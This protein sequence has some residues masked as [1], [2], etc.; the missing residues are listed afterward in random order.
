MTSTLKS[1]FLPPK[2]PTV[3]ALFVAALLW[4]DAAPAQIYRP[5]RARRT[6]N[7]DQYTLVIQKNSQIDLL[8]VSGE[9]LLDNAFP[10]V[11]FE[12]GKELPL[13]IDFKKTNRFSV[14]SPIGKGN[15]FLYA[16]EE[17]EWRIATYPG[18]GCMT[19]D[20][21]F[22]NNTK[23]PLTV[24]GLSPL[25]TGNEGKGGIFLG[26]S[27]AETWVLQAPSEAHPF[28]HIGSG[29]EASPG[30][31]AAWS[32]ATG[33]GLVAGFLSHRKSLGIVRLSK[34]T[35]SENGIYDLF[36]SVCIFDEPI[37]VEPGGRL[38]AETLYLAMGEMEP[39]MALEAFVDASLAVEPF[40][41]RT[42]L[43]GWLPQSADDTNATS[44]LENL[45]AS[46]QRMVPA[47]WTN[48]N[49]GAHWSSATGEGAL[50]PQRFPN[51]LSALVT[52]ARSQGAKTISA[53]L[54]INTDISAIDTNLNK[55]KLSNID[56]AELLPATNSPNSFI[57]TLH[58]IEI[59][60]LIATST[61]DLPKVVFGRTITPGQAPLMDWALASRSYYLP[62]IGNPLLAPWARELA[63][64]TAHFSD[65]QF[66]TAFTLAAI[67]GK[68][69]RPA[70]PWTTL[71]PL[72]QHVLSRL[73]PTPANSG[74]PLDLF[75]EGPPRQWY[76]PLRTKVGDWTVAALFN[77]EQ[78][79]SVELNTPLTAFGLNNDNLYTV[80][81]FWAGQY[82]GLIE[83]TLRVE[84]PPQGVRLLGLRRY[85]RR[86]MLVASSRHYTQGASDHTALD[87]N[88]EAG[89]LTGT[90]TGIK[91]ETCTLS[92]L[93][94]EPWVVK[95]AT[96]SVEVVTQKQTGTLLTLSLRPTTPGDVTW[97]VTF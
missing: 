41:T 84:V 2:F 71:S 55:L 38:E 97:K 68:P 59:Q 89:I 77:W 5:E 65:E 25:G 82:L 60:Q 27:T 7:T 95:A 66:I 30:H 22:T 18:N 42:S 28:G 73:L 4:A 90:F 63:Q 53:T 16:T 96:S 17:C 14:Q 49:L 35:L 94:P 92:I 6:I 23:S 12:D 15:G 21:T 79:A 76:L 54:E 33:H 86:P 75:Q 29:A 48:L 58:P 43:H 93:V 3:L 57:P 51:G 85:E 19:F 72:R 9:P 56:V 20:L 78:G 80:Y 52:A 31:L 40:P 1:P 47:G 24:V 74:R 87:W 81:D 83:K 91:D 11:I 70:N 44:L 36:S 62:T 61:N 67:Q 13:K 10:S 8:T 26:S 45:T 88:H 46:Q 37:I 69:L 50:D 34:S 64:D 32:P 39:R